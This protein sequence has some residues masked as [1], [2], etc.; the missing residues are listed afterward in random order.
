MRV[1]DLDGSGASVLFLKCTGLQQAV[2]EKRVLQ[3]GGASK[4]HASFE[5]AARAGIVVIGWHSTIKPGHLPGVA[6]FTNISTD[7]LRVARV[8]A[9]LAVARS[10]DAAHVVIFTDS[11]GQIS[12]LK[13][14]PVV[15]SIRASLG[16]G[17]LT[18]ID[19]PLAQ[20]SERIL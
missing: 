4:Q 9:A 17:V 6:L 15:A 12:V 13:S 2:I 5:R 1:G 20:V 10:N 18:T 16:C 7:P 8:A 3:S 19:T 11:T 14:N